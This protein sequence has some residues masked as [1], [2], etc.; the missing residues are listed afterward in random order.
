MVS[1]AYWRIQVISFREKNCYDL[2]FTTLQGKCVR[3]E[4][5]PCD[6]ALVHSNISALKHAA[7]K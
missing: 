7:N 6:Q 2:D 5:I 3:F 1:R 4:N